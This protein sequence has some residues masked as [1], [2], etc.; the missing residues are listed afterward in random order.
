ML[1]IDVTSS[2]K[3]PMNT[4]VQRVVRGLFRAWTDLLGPAGV[5][6]VLWEPRLTAYCSL[7]SR[8]RGFLTDPFAGSTGRKSRAEPGKV[9]NR[10][11]V[12]S[13]WW[14][15]VTH[16]RNRLD[17]AGAMTAGDTLFVP[18][19]FQDNRVAW[20]SGLGQR[21]PARRVAVCH[22]A[23][24]WRNPEMT[25]AARLSGFTGY[26]NSLRKFD[27]ILAVSQEASNDLQALWRKEDAVGPV[28]PVRVA[29]W[30]ADD[31][32]AGS[33]LPPSPTPWPQILCVGTFEPR[34]NHPALLAAA[35]ILWAQGL[36]FE[37][38]LVGRTTA[39]WGGAVEREIERLRAAGRAVTWRRHVDDETLR[40]LYRDCVFTVFPSLAEGFGIPIVESLRHGRPCVC[41][42]NG[43]LGELSSGGG[44]LVVD[45]QADPGDLADGIQRLLTD[46]SL[47]G[48]LSEEARTRVFPTWVDYVRRLRP[49]VLAPDDGTVSELDDHAERELR[50]EA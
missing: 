37:L 25:L 50:A 3:S 48:R 36:R 31:A 33:A 29:G 32:F 23:I 6:P 22:D 20:L 43:A 24:G 44:C 7:S 19:I 13:K 42:G 12:F 35:E 11:P 45:D 38:V 18:E 46:E 34:K 1:Y 9:A 40:E 4:G 39:G 15:Q 17:L 49:F 47:R 14:R 8:E 21:C 27:G 2:C 5:V 26:L 30:P 10:V 28:P 41:G 16:R